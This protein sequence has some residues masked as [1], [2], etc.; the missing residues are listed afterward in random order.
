MLLLYVLTKAGITP[1]RLLGLLAIALC[2]VA[3]LVSPVVAGSVRGRVIVTGSGGALAR[4]NTINPYPGMLGSLDGS[5]RD[6]RGQRRDD[7]PRDVVIFLQPDTEGTPPKTTSHQPVLRQINQRFEPRVLGIPVGTTVSF[8]NDDLIL[9]NVFSYSKAKRFDLG[10]YG[11]GKS[12]NVQFDK[13]GIIKVFCDIHSNM[14]AFIYVVDSQFV[15]QPDGDGNFRID[16]LP[17]G[18]QELNIWHPDRGMRTRTVTVTDGETAIE[19]HI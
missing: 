6:D 19:I 12:K 14:A 9:H 16:Q 17:E 5:L 15:T 4:A 3:L 1:A 10:Y 18:V 7:D 13:P 11:K 8:P 2:L